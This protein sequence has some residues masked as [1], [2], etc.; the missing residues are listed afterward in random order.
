MEVLA[1]S[2]LFPVLATIVWLSS[3]MRGTATSARSRHRVTVMLVTYGI[4]LIPAVLIFIS[5]GLE[6]RFVTW[7][8]P[9]NFWIAAAIISAMLAI[10]IGTILALGDV[11]LLK[12]TS[13]KIHP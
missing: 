6:F 13:S 11:I 8:G 2:A 7:G 12:V 9:D 1:A 3:F 10:A 5:A 4:V